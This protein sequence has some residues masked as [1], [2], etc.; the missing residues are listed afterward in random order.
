[1]KKHGL[2]AR[3]MVA[4]RSVQVEGLPTTVNS[5]TTPYNCRTEDVIFKIHVYL[6]QK[7]CDIQY[8]LSVSDM[9][10]LYFSNNWVSPDHID[11]VPHEQIAIVSFSDPKG[12]SNS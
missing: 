3:P 12:F 4:A 9:L 2:T 5:G 11:M 6:S 7:S 8:L 10:D 1:M